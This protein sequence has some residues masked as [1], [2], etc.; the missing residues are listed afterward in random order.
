LPAGVDRHLQGVS[1]DVTEHGRLDSAVGKI[2]KRPVFGFGI[3]FVIPGAMLHLRRR[4]PHGTRVT[5]AR[6]LVD[7]WTTWIPQPEQLGYFV[8]RFSRCVIAG[9][10]DVLV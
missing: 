7:N 2:K 8:E 6:E 5:M 10:A 1:L 4:K 3:A 9:V